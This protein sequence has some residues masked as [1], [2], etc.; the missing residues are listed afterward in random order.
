MATSEWGVPGNAPGATGCEID[1]VEDEPAA[2]TADT[3]T[4]YAVPLVRPVMVRDV[5]G[6]IPSLNVVQVEPLLLEYCTR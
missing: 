6:E 2:L 5:T 1:W 4:R 3:L